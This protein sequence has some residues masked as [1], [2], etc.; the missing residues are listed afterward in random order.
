MNILDPDEG[1]I[2]AGTIDWGHSIY[3]E[4]SGKLWCEVIKESN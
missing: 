2:H 4:N 3:L 1:L